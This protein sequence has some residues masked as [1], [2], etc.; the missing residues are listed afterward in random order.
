MRKRIG[1]V[2]EALPGQQRFNKSPPA[3]HSGYDIT[4]QGKNPGDS[5]ATPQAAQMKRGSGKLHGSYPKHP[6][7]L[8]T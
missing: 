8:R 3:D 5:A 7:K 6:Q 2:K 4:Y 1:H